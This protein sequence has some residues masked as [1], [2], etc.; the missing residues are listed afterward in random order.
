MTYFWRMALLAFVLLLF[1]FCACTAGSPDAGTNAGTREEAL[2]AAASEESSLGSLDTVSHGSS[3]AEHHV[4]EDGTAKGADAAYL[5]AEAAARAAA[6]AAE[7]IPKLWIEY[8]LDEKIQAKYDIMQE[9]KTTG[10]IDE[11]NRFISRVL[12]E[13]LQK[14]EPGKENRL[15]ANFNE[16]YPKMAEKLLTVEEE[17]RKEYLNAASIEYVKPITEELEGKFANACEYAQYLFTHARYMFHFFPT[18][19]YRQEIDG[20]VYGFAHYGSRCMR[21]V[22]YPIDKERTYANYTV[23]PLD[24]KLDLYDDRCVEGF[25]MKYRGGLYRLTVN[26]IDPEVKQALYELEKNRLNYKSVCE[27]K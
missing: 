18:S 7:K 2:G 19:E 16:W 3:E 20:V 21:F 14:N 8:S 10:S 5:A 1:Y 24:G 13:Y 25:Q 26:A 6:Q 17:E 27:I 23:I 4:P 9:T 22:A 12:Y 15:V 11:Y